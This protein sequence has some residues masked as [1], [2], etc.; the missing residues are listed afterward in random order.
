M[1]VRAR[2]KEE[3]HLISPLQRLGTDFTET[4]VREKALVTEGLERGDDFL[5]GVLVV[6]TGRLEEV[7]LLVRAQGL[8]A[9]DDAVERKVRQTKGGEARV[10][11][12]EPRRHTFGASSPSC[13]RAR[14]LLGQPHP[15]FEH[16]W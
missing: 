10:G 14:G 5:D 7:D 9:V 8:L 6:E 4:D 3:T 2:K 1:A 16:E 11:R 15:T 12:D 13:Y